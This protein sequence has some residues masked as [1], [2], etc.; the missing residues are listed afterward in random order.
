[1]PSHRLI[2][3]SAVVA[4]LFAATAAAAPA[5]DPFASVDEKLR[6]GEW[7]AGRV[8]ALAQLDSARGSLYAPYLG[9]AVARLAVAEAGLGRAEDAIWHWQVAQNLDREPLSA[10]ALAAMGAP[11][12]LLTRHRLRLAGEPPA[13]TT[14]HRVEGAADTLQPARKLA[15][16]PPT[17]S[18]LVAGLPVPK[19]LRL[20]AVVGTDG[21]LLAPVVVGGG[22]PGMI[23]EALEAVRAWRYE[24]A[25]KGGEAGGEAVV[26]FR[27]LRFDVPQRRP[28]GELIA[29]SAPAGEAEA[30]LRAG[31]WQQAE[32]AAKRAWE[33]ALAV[34]QP[35]REL[36][37]ANLALRALAEAG[38][39]RT[40]S[41]VCRWQ[42]AQHV[43]ERLYG[44]DLSPYG[45]AGVLLDRHR[46][47]SAPA[48]RAT[49]DVPPTLESGGP[50]RLP[51]LWKRTK[52]RGLALLTATLDERGG[53]HQPLII[54]LRDDDRADPDAP[55]FEFSYAPEPLDFTRLG[56]VAALFELCD[57]TFEPARLADQPVTS[58]VIVVVPYGRSPTI[59]LRVR[60]GGSGGN[61]AAGAGG[62][63]IVGSESN[64][65][66]RRWP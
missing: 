64:I 44:A 7:E 9:G 36:L 42:A 6:A 14:V 8:L 47:G 5:P 63:S 13:G 18:G 16:E 65:G 62:W 33:A 24:P 55:L 15:G 57:W 35:R 50:V 2:L 20:E 59:E 22:A 38:A 54:G 61:R 30:F 41:A 21:R 19:A 12:A 60:P 52:F 49:A 56:A 27:D 28:I 46:W 29:L 32:R 4:C 58:E 66:L 39:G 45:A 1:M 40:A 37:A 53:L 10:E 17:F 51:A 23:W 34:R 3:P 25:R 43:D 26:V 48:A 31:S 11:G